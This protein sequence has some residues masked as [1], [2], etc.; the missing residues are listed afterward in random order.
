ASMAVNELGPMLTATEVE[1]P[2]DQVLVTFEI[3]NLQPTSHFAITFG[4]GQFVGGVEFPKA[5]PAGVHQALKLN[6][7]TLTFS[8][9]ANT[10]PSGYTT[11]GFVAPVVFSGPGDGMFDAKAPLVAQINAGYGAITSRGAFHLVLKSLPPTCTLGC[12]EPGMRCG[13]SPGASC[14]LYDSNFMC[15]TVCPTGC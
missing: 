4:H 6:G 2:A 14:Y 7:N 5:T 1:T 10:L 3:F 8:P 11:I 15:C 13:Q 9:G 12:L